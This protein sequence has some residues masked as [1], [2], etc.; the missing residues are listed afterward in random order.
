VP[1]APAATPSG[2]AWVVITREPTSMSAEAGVP[3]EKETH[4]TAKAFGGAS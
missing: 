1:L 4:E 2:S 3:M